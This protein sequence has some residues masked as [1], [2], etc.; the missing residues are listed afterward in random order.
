MIRKAPLQLQHANGKQLSSNCVVDDV[1]IDGYEALTPPAVL[2]QLLPLSDRSR[3]TIVDARHE[4]AD[5]LNGKDDRVLAIVG[6]CSIHDTEAALEYGMRFRELALELRQDVCLIMRAYFEKPRTTV[7]WKGL[8]NDP[9]LDGSF[10]IN[11]GLFI[12]RKLLCD[13]VSI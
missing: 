3:Q 4:A 11:D 5:I 9:Y 10:Q 1:R 13:L 12:A 7:G 2:S 6:P 8:I